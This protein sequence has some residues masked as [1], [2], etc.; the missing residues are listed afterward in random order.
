[1]H[2]AIQKGVQVSKSDTV[3]FKHNDVQDLE[4]KILEVMDGKQKVRYACDVLVYIGVD[5]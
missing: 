4:K 3:W 2:F 1:M 5:V